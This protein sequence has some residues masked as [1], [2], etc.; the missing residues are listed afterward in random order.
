MRPQRLYRGAV[1][2]VFIAAMILDFG[3]FGSPK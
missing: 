2:K 3:I 1:D